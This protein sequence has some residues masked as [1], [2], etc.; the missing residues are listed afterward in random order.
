MFCKQA[1]KAHN[2]CG[3]AFEKLKNNFYKKKEKNK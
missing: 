1:I 2:N 3:E